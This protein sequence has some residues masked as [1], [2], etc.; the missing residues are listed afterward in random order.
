MSE[1]EN[2][3]EIE[4]KPEEK[5][6]AKIS[7]NLYQDI[8]SLKEKNIYL[9]SESFEQKIPEIL[10]YL[11]SKSA[12]Y[13]IANKIQILIYLQDLIK[14]VDFH[15]EIFSSKKSLNENLNIFQVIINQII[16][17]DEKGI[18]YIK[19][20]KKNFILLLNK[21][22]L[23]RKTFKYIFSFL[24][25]YLNKDEKKLIFGN[26]TRILDLLNIFYTNISNI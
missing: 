12:E 26:I 22:T 23:D 3:A 1:K 7:P 9:I 17:S 19:E 15:A 8:I 13:P 25:N 21:I 10:S 18:D 14:K 2:K 6:E 20:L 24:I 16:T 11:L 4:K 5:V